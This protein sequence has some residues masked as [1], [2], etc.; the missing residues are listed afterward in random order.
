MC[1]DWCESRESSEWVAGISPR[2]RGIEILPS[3]KIEVADIAF[4]WIEQAIEIA[5]QVAVRASLS[6]IDA[7]VD[8]HP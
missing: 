7:L 8:K 2:F 3:D 5:N 6:R 1:T 4:H